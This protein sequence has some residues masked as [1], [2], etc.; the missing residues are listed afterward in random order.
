MFEEGPNG[1]DERSHEAFAK[2]LAELKT[3]GSAVLI[4]GADSSTGHHTLCRRLLGVDSVEPRRQ[5]LLGTDG[6]DALD[7]RLP[8]DGGRPADA[9]LISVST[10]RGAVVESTPDPSPTGHDVVELG[11][12]SLAT[13][14]HTIAEAFDRV[15]RRY[16]P[17]EPTEVRFG[18]ESVRPLLDVYGEA[19]FFSFLVMLTRYFRAFDVLG[20]VHLRGDLNEYVARLLAPL[21]DVVVEFRETEGHLQHR[22]HLDDGAITSR[23]VTA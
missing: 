12:A 5:I 8:T 9:T 23:W 20:H 2:R 6:L 14:G 15:E 10:V 7:A 11:N 18:I 17:L 22:W 4:V 19:P 13:L 16:A 1:S 3:G 21:F